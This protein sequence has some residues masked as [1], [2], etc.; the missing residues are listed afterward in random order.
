MYKELRSSGALSYEKIEQ[1]F[2]E[3]QGKWPE[4]IFNE[5]AQFK[6]LDPLI[7]DNDAAYLSMLQGSKAEQRKWWLWNRFRYLDSKYNAGDAL[8]QVITLRGYA[9][10]DITVTPY[11]SIYATIKYGSYLVQQR[12]PRN[13]PVTLTNPLDNVNDTE[14]YIYSADQIADIG[15]ISGLKVGYANF[16]YATKLVNLKVG[17]SDPNYSNLNLGAH[18]TPALALGNN[19]LLQTL[20]VRNCPNLTEVVDLSGCTN[21]EEVYFDGTSI[22]GV[23]LPNGGVLNTLHLPDTVTNLTIRNQLNITDFVLNNPTN[24]STLVLEN[25]SGIDSLSLLR[26]MQDG[27]RVRLIGF[28]WNITESISDIIAILNRQRGIDENGNTVEKAQLYG[29]INVENSHEMY[30]QYFNEFYPN[31]TVNITNSVPPLFW[32]FAIYGTSDASNLRSWSV[33]E[34]ILPAVT[35]WKLNGRKLMSSN[36]VWFPNVTQIS[37][38]MATNASQTIYVGIGK[39]S[40]TEIAPLTVDTASIFGSANSKVYVPDELVNDYKEAT[41]WSVYAS[42][43]YPLSEAPYTE[44]NGGVY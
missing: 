33:E 6:Y 27:G 25:V 30:A 20:D 35:C 22:A 3:H 15:D 10:D 18:Q 24:I 44:W 31:V 4:A 9:K 2:E 11:A 41:N 36:V 14:I 39:Q 40:D 42:Q 29:V 13:V 38:A 17:D 1:M 12:A 16:T 34:G 43:I 19:T 26:R 7:D 23:S 8:T 5:D 28:E 32:R 37:Y 21:I